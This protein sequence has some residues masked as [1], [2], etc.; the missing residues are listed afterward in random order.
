MEQLFLVLVT[1]KTSNILED[2]ETLR[3]LAKTVQDAC[4][5]HAI[6]EETV[7]RNAFDIIFA[8]DETISFG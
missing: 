1:N 6:S 5:H 2:L 8:F 7:L 3:L 4:K